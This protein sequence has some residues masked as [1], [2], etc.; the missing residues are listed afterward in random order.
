L[1]DVDDRFLWQ[2]VDTR[3]PD[4]VC[5]ELMYHLLGPLPATH[6]RDCDG[7]HVDGAKSDLSRRDV[8]AGA[9]GFLIAGAIP[10]A[11]TDESLNT[12]STRAQPVHI[13]PET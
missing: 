6:S 4:V 2:C 5:R 12:G 1:V 9:T 3:F 11:A 8:L 13:T 7:A 10:L